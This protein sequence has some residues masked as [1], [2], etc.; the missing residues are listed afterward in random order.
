MTIQQLFSPWN[1]SMV[2]RSAV[3]I[4]YSIHYLYSGQIS[5]YF[6]RQSWWF[7]ELGIKPVYLS[8]PQHKLKSRELLKVYFKKKPLGALHR[9]ERDLIPWVLSLEKCRSALSVKAPPFLSLLLLYRRLY[10]HTWHLS[11]AVS[12]VT[13]TNYFVSLYLELCCILRSM[14]LFTKLTGLSVVVTIN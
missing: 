6:C 5:G 13:S 9:E 2:A 4:K 3:L 11:S 1:D 12:P 10:L 7:N 14:N 8:C